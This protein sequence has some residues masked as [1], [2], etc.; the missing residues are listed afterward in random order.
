MLQKG[1]DDLISR[2]QIL[3]DIAV[4]HKVDA[5]GGATHKYDIVLGWSSDEIRHNLPRT[6]IGIRRAGSQLVGTAMDIGV[7]VAI[8][9]GQTIDDRLR[10]LCRCP[11]VQPDEIMPVDFF[12]QYGEIPPDI[13][14]RFRADGDTLCLGGERFLCRPAPRCAFRLLGRNDRRAVPCALPA[15]IRRNFAQ[16][17]S[18]GLCGIL[19]NVIQQTSIV[20]VGYKS[21]LGF[22]S[23]LGCGMVKDLRISL[24]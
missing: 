6:L 24:I 9:M 19:Q 8:V 10:T 22:R 20:P 18:V 7:F 17:G 14:Q 16:I 5:L 12:R 21:L 1:Q 11:V 3:L 13:L 4:G 23:R 2:L 15:C